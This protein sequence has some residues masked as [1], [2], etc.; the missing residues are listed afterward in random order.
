MSVQIITSIEDMQ[1]ISSRWRLDGFR[2]GFVP[3]M[4]NLHEGHLRLVEKAK[5]NVDKV[6]ISIFVNP[7]QFGPNEDFEKYPRTLDADIE[8]LQSLSVDAVF[9]PDEKSFYRNDKDKMTYVEVPGLSDIL[10]G[11]S[12]PGHF[13]GVTTVVN[14]LFNIVQADIAVFGSKDYQ[15]LTIIRQM[16]EELAMPVKIIGMDTVREIDGLA[17]SSRN[18]YL[19]T[20]QRNIAPKL[21]QC[22]QSMRQVIREDEQDLTKLVTEYK[23]VLLKDGF[24]IDYLEIRDA[25]SFQSIEEPSEN[26]VILTA[27]WL[28]DTRLIDNILV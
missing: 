7:L 22:L 3:T 17:M 6:V 9:A 18:R 4:G 23:K 20:E 16:V 28:G 21:Y 12:R 24:Q 26:M 15:Q 10:C 11:A 1:T 8:K 19:S 14:K 13:R 5:Q 27:V 2:I 25:H